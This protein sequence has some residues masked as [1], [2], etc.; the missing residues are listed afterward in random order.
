MQITPMVNWDCLHVGAL[1]W[2]DAR[3]PIPCDVPQGVTLRA[4]PARMSG[5]LFAA[6]RAWEKGSMGWAQVFEDGGRLRMWYSVSAPSPESYERLCYAESMDGLT[7]HKPELGLIA[8]KGSTANNVVYETLGMSHACVVNCPHEPP[9]K[10]YQCMYFKA[11]WEGEPGEELSSEE[12]HHRLDVKNAARPGEK[13]LPVSLQGKMMGMTSPD[14]FRWTPMAAPI[15]D[16]WHDTHNICVYDSRAGLYRAYL[17][18]CYG[19]RRAVAYSETR[20]FAHWP[21]SR[22]IHHALPTDGPDESLYSNAY[23]RYPGCPELHL[24]FPSI[25]QQ[26]TDSTYG[27][28]AVSSDGLNWARLTGQVII[29]SGPPGAAD[30]GMV[31]PEPELLRCSN[32][33]VMRLLCVCSPHF[34][35]EWYNERLRAGTKPSFYRWAEWP[36]DRLVGLVAVGDGS[37]T[38]Q[39]QTCGDQ[40][41]A[42]YRCEPG[43]WIRFELVDR[44]VWPP[45]PMPGIAG[46][47][48]EEAVPL[49]GDATHAP[50]QWRSHS[51]T[52]K[53]HGQTVAIRVRLH[54]ATLFSVTTYGVNDPLVRKDP[55]FPV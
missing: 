43:G 35:N 50:L 30:E 23:T 39:T 48:F 12:G 20:D 27:E 28:F 49:T 22:V 34:H 5:P 38:L 32:Q 18:G 16:E 36:E 45:Q 21:P 19:A 11:W 40:I 25:Y 33:G 47:C 31:Y 17:R 9:D 37:V 26:S 8:I 51:S 55:R 52:A 4:E 54:K 1:G 44:L 7:W 53:L 41:L 6:D 2:S 24:M 13:T 42:N 15:L 29:P 10:R 14:G 3:K 46:F